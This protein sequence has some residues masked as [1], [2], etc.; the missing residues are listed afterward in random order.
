MVASCVQLLLPAHMT[1]VERLSIIPRSGGSLGFTYM[2]PME[3]RALMFDRCGV[4]G[5][6]EGSVGVCVCVEGCVGVGV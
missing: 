3:D 1:S 4:G 5:S 2:P 6:V